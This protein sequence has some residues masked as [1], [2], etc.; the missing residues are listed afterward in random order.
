[1]QCLFWLSDAS[2]LMGIFEVEL[3]RAYLGRDGGK[4]DRENTARTEGDAIHISERE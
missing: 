2:S 1:M 3:F 4:V